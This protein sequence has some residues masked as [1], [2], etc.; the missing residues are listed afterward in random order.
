MFIL[1]RNS[2]DCQEYKLG[3]FDEIDCL[4]LGTD[5]AYCNNT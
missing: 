3:I 5:R 1:F 2:L 4:E